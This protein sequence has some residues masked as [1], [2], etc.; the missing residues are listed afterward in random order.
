M[1]VFAN[2]ATT[3]CGGL[4]SQADALKDDLAKKC[5]APDTDWHPIWKTSSP[6][7]VEGHFTKAEKSESPDK[8]LMSSASRHRQ[9]EG[10]PQTSRGKLGRA[11]K[12]KESE[13]EKKRRP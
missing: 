10:G 2:M 12:K 3:E 11:M 13:K 4:A 1:L 8:L 6:E 9:Q 7:G 5:F